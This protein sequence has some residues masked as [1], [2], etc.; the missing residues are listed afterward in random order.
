MRVPIRDLVGD[1]G[2]WAGLNASAARSIQNTRGRRSNHV[3]WLRAFRADLE[4]YRQY[5]PGTLTLGLLFLHQGL[6]ALLQ[7]RIANAL[8]RSALP[9]VIKGPGL[10]LAVGWQKMIE[11]ATG[12]EIP[13]RTTIAPGLYIGHFGNLRFHPDVVIGPMCNVAPGVTIGVSGRGDRRGVPVIGERVF[14]G[15]NAVVVG[16]IT[17]GNDAVIAANALITR[18]VPARAVVL[19]NPARIVSYKGS[20]DYI[21]P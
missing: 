18:D 4:R 17:V 15:P 6:W 13:Y 1:R 9:R 5:S 20:E 12:I 2:L 3:T 10:F 11:I 19:G 16:K 7:Y 8:Y 21:A 14:V